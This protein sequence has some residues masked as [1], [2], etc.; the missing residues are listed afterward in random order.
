MPHILLTGFEPFNK[1]TTN[2]AWEVVKLFESKKIRQTHTVHIAQLP[3]EFGRANT[4]L[5]ALLTQIQ[6]EIVICVGQAGGRVDISL[7]RIAINID[8]A[9]IPDN[10]GAQPIDQSIVPEGPAAYFS[11]L[12][13]KAI[14]KNLQDNGIPAS[15]S[16]TAGTYVCNHVFYRLMHYA[17]KSTQVLRAGFVHI[18]Y[19]PSQACAHPGAA[20]MAL[21]QMEKA[22][23]LI[24]E[25][26]ITQVNDL[27]LGAGATH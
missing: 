23:Y 9:R 21:A 15:V 1:E 17:N 5:T 27:K 10:A 25:T 8:D 12:P 24:L 22:L 16:Q 20:S 2:P 4:A 19:L 11:T 3:C 18:P 26:S 14:V 7:E 6:P 13:I